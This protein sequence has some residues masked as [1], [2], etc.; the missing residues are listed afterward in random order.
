MT[1]SDHVKLKAQ[2]AKSYRGMNASLILCME[3]VDYQGICSDC[4][5]RWE[6]RA[7]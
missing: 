3:M 7:S 5:I 2:V 6:A 4:G 1:R